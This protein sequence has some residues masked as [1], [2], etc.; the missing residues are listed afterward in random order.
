MS[1]WMRLKTCLICG[2]AGY[3]TI[4]G[5]RKV[6]KCM[7][8]PNSHPIKQKDGSPAW[9]HPADAASQNVPARK[10]KDVPRLKTKEVAE[11]VKRHQSELTAKRLDPFAKAMQLSVGSL[12]AYGIG[13]DVERGAFSFPMV[14]GSLKL[15]GIRLRSFGGRKSC[16]VGSRNGL[17]V[18]GDYDTFEI[19]A[20]MANDP[21]P[22]LLLMPE[23]PTDAAAARDL[24]FRAIGRPSNAGGADMLE[25]LL[26]SGHKQEVVIVADRDE[27]KYL[28]DGTPFW[29]GIEGA[30][31][32]CERILPACGRLQFLMPPDGVKD[33]RDWSIA[34][35][36]PASV[37]ASLEKTVFVTEAW[38]KKAR[39]RIEDRKKKE[40]KTEAA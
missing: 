36:T 16:V 1:G 8:A 2:H 4:S 39:N 6:I 24:G 20:D 26:K 18:P 3:C 13:W 35:T 19:P 10:V 37:L 17:F 25:Q 30:L 40:R 22:L 28:G 29:P 11:L 15:C 21:H 32:V 31:N 9:I 12:K 5:D 27:T 23:G 33:I 14:D 34:G 7:R 38:L